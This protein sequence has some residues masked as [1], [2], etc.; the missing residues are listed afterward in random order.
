[1][2]DQVAHPPDVQYLT[3][4][5]AVLLAGVDEEVALPAQLDGLPVHPAGDLA[6]AGDGVGVGRR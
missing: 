6:A 2:V 5:H 1:V 4:L 3:A